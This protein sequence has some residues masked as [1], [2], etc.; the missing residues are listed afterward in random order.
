MKKGQ[1][2]SI[3]ISSIC[4]FAIPLSV[5]SFGFMIPAQYDETYYGELPHMFKHLK[6]GKEGK[7]IIVGNSAVAFASRND[8]IEQELNKE[9]VTFG[10]YGA[11]GTKAMMDLSKAGIKKNDVVILS[12]EISDQGLSLYFSSE[13]MW[14]GIDGH[15]D[16]LSYI[17]KDNRKSMIGNFASF[18]SSKFNYLRKGQK[19]KVEGVYQQ[20]SFNLGD[21]ETGYMT[22][23]REYNMMLNGYDA[24]SLII[25][26]QNYLKDDFIS[27]MNKYA[28]YVYKKGASIY[29]NFVPCNS[30]A[31]TSSEEEI[32][33]F[34]DALSSK[35]DF[36][37][38]GNPHDYI[39][40]YE[41]FYD[42]NSH[43]NS[44]GTNLYNRQLVE[45]LKVVLNDSTPTNI[46]IP[47]KPDIPVPEYE[48][49]DN[50]D[51]DCFNY[52]INGDGYQITSLTEKGKEKT[53]LIIPSTYNEKPIIS[54][55]ADVF[56][57]N[58]KINQVIVPVNIRTLGDYSFEGCSNLTKII[59]QHDNPNK[60]NV[61]TALL[62]GADNCNVYVK[63][64]CYDIFTT[65]YNWGYYRD[66]LR[67]Y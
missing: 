67:K 65:H 57:G 61:G 41:W 63:E 42:N 3:V 15:Y 7:I 9:V 59:I 53:T 31:V 40:D 60:I 36:P 11:I 44:A 47:E 25:F 64:S 54:F 45:D 62:F 4:L 37:I 19:P 26:D 12:P 24:N 56:K 38:L 39:F 10:L 27:Y 43:L 14:M 29:Y 1:I 58:K 8:L 51:L 35:I 5:V 66:R 50:S 18:A 28:K 20:A 32:D 30:L 23:E 52:E 33:A 21:I 17:A 6:E 34:Y 48:D 55:S 49:G 13:N 2:I 22:Y 46:D 16:M